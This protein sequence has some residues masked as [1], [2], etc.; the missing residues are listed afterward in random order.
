MIDR[1][2]LFIERGVDITSPFDEYPNWAALARGRTPIEFAAVC[3]HTA[4]V[5]LLEAYGAELPE[6]SPV[7]AYVAALLR[8]D[9]PDGDA[10]EAIAAR[11]SLAVQAVTTARTEVVRNVVAAGFDVNALGR[12]DAPAEDP[13]QTPLHTAVE[14]GNAEMVQLL[15]E[16]GADPSIED[17]RYHSTP[18]G[19]AEH[20]G[21]EDLAALLR[22]PA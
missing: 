8:G 11:P 20:F 12:A 21:Y 4:I 3:G 13:W 7:D 6:L 9:T 5:N 10:T 15:L 14:Y 18:L 16:L 1:V 17:C 2:R 19:W 22:S